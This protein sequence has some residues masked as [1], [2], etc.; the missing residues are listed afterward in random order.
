L[1]RD[2]IFKVQAILTRFHV[3][4]LV[5]ANLIRARLEIIRFNI[6]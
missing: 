3:T 2:D 1:M 4:I 5:L 6:R